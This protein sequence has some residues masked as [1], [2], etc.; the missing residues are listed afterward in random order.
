M[1]IRFTIE[2]GGNT[3]NVKFLRK[4]FPLLEEEALRVIQMMP[5][6]Q[7]GKQNGKVVPVCFTMPFIIHL[8]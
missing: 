1:I 3:T 6:W 8:L 4:A 5:C 7:P 2:K